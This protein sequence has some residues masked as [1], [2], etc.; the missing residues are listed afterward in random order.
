M[1]KSM[2]MAGCLVLGAAGGAVVALLMG[3]SPPTVTAAPPANRT[4][5]DA[6]AAEVKRLERR[7]EELAVAVLSSGPTGTSEPG[8]APDGSGEAGSAGDG[9]G[10][11]ATTGS[12]ADRVAVLEG[13]IAALEKGGMQSGPAVPKDLASVPSDELD[14][15]ARN[16]VQMKRY[17]DARRVLKELLGRTDMVEEQR[18]EMEMQL[19]YALRGSGKFADSEARF[20]DTLNRVG[21]DTEKGAW[22]GFQAAWDRYYQKDPAGASARMERSANASGVSAVVRVHSL[23]NAAHFAKEAGDPARARVFLERLLND[24]ADDIPPA[25]AFMKSQAEAW[26]KEV[27]GQ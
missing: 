5:S 6:G 18:T 12:L 17:D 16:L 20:L 3:G 24:H 13:R 27:S 26:L 25:Q 19:G 8:A 22:A 1:G 9:G 4:G 14:A 7:V 21:E 15:L 11:P 10:T 2:L 23:Y